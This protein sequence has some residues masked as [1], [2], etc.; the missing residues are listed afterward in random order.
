MEQIVQ[1][2]DQLELFSDDPVKVTRLVGEL[3]VRLADFASDEV[4]AYQLL[5]EERDDL[6]RQLAAICRE[7]V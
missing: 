2:L 3:R 4:D 7:P 5:L 6:L 1:C